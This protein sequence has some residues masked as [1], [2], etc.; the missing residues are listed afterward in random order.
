MTTTVKTNRI[1]ETTEFLDADEMCQIALRWPMNRKTLF[2][3]AYEHDHKLVRAQLLY[4]LN[5]DNIPKGSKGKFA[6]TVI[7]N[8]AKR[9]AEQVAQ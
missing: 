9:Q 7:R 4:V 6:T 5:R 8:A 2:E 1:A 3:L